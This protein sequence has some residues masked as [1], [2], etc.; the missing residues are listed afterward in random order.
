MS[1][2]EFINKAPIAIPAAIALL[3]DLKKE[4]RSDFQ[5]KMFDYLKKMAKLP[6]E[7]CKKLIEELL[8]QGI[9]GFTEEHAVMLANILPRNLDEVKAVLSE[10]INLSSENLKK[11]EEVLNKYI[12]NEG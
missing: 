10:K 11:I 8:S 3:K 2:I 9:P 12:K 7:S 4:E 1:S 6:E 5:N